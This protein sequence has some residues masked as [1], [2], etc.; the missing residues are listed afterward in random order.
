MS[1]ASNAGSTTA[2]LIIDDSVSKRL[3]QIQHSKSSTDG[4]VLRIAVDAGGC[5]GFS[6]SFKLDDATSINPS[7]DI[8]YNLSNNNRVVID[9]LSLELIRGSK[10]LWNVDGLVR[11]SFAVIDNPNAD[12]KCGCGASFNPKHVTV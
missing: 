11:S 2:D 9:K 12:S 5:S 3:N 8:V 1:N 10:L 7:D 6:Y 4:L